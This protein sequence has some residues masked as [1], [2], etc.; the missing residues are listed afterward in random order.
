MPRDKDVLPLGEERDRISAIPRFDRATSAP[1]WRP[2]GYPEDA[3]AM[4]DVMLAIRNFE[5]TV[6]QMKA[7]KFKPRP[8]F[9][10]IGATHLSIGQEGTAVGA[11]SAIR[12]DDYITSTHRGH[13]HSI[14]KGFYWL[15]GR[16]SDDELRAFIDG[17]ADPNDYEAWPSAPCRCT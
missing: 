3:V 2:G 16:T 8:D 4:L 1:S 14:A 13:G 12:P 15:R 6:A 9:R 7:G 5:E 10:F 11:V 17:Y